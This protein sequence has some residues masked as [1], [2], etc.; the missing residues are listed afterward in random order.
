MLRLSLVKTTEEELNFITPDILQKTKIQFEISK[1]F[2]PENSVRELVVINKK[3]LRLSEEKV[4][5]WFE[6]EDLTLPERCQIKIKEILFTIKDRKKIHVPIEK[7]YPFLLIKS[8]SIERSRTNSEMTAHTLSISDN[9][10]PLF[11]MGYF[12]LIAKHNE[13][14]LIS[15]L[16]LLK[17][18]FFKLNLIDINYLKKQFKKM[19]LDTLIIYLTDNCEI[20]VKIC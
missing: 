2:E 11:D 14:C 13:T 8:E 5:F 9:V 4:S 3:H 1:I 15:T 20:Q 10:D 12:D 16:T 7:S 18:R 17:K 19:Y 6:L